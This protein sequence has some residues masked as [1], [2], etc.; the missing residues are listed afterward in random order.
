VQVRDPLGVIRYELYR[1]SKLGQ[2][3]V[4]LPLA[5]NDPPGTW[6]VDIRELL[7]HTGETVTFE[8][9]PPVD[10]RSI[11]GATRR[12]VV[13][14]NDRDNAFRFGRLFHDVTIVKGSSPF[15]DAAA[16]RLT[17]IL[18]PWGV[19]CKLMEL[20]EAAKP[21]TLTEEEARTWVGL[22]HAGKGQI[23]PGAGNTPVY[24]GFA[25]QG[26]VILLGNP[27]DNPIIK[28]LLTE[29]YLPYTPSPGTFPGVGRGMYA[30]QRDGVG[31]GQESITLIAYDEAGMNEAV[32]SFYEAVA[33]LEPLTKWAVP[34]AGRTTPAKTAPGLAR[35]ATVVWT[36]NLPDR[37]V[38]IGAGKDGVT[39]LAHDGSLATVNAQGKVMGNK[40]LTAAEVEQAMKELSQPADA[41]ALKKQERPDRLAKLAAGHNGMV[42]VAYWGGTL[43]VVDGQGV[44]KTEQQLPQDVTALT[45]FDRKVVAGLA[46]GRVL[47][48]EVP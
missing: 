28:Y 31:R 8:Y 27:E 30:W 1:A 3:A 43:R 20:A 39:A 37:V 33:G 9:A 45:W 10:V 46:D 4:S 34:P 21:R 11:A 23:K 42:A 35:A 24:A 2:F 19:R 40:A 7:N 47:G 6:Q 16:K 22:V 17:T 18:E 13:A 5:A 38:A 25:V 12:A 48:L 36:A 41:A 15:N 32:G 26:P 29:K 14:A 44:V